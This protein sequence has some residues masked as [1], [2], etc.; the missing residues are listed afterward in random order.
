M[1]QIA[2]RFAFLLEL[3]YNKKTDYLAPSPNN[4]KRV[5]NSFQMIVKILIF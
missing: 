3:L 1:Q 5:E 2:I 4:F